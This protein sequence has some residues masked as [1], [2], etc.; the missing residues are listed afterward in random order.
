MRTATALL[1]AALL[2]AA[3]LA[4]PAWAQAPLANPGFEEGAP[5]LTGWRF[6]Q[7][8]RYAAALD[9]VGAREGRWAAH[10]TGQPGGGA[11][12]FGNL[13]QRVDAVPFRGQRLRFRAWVRTD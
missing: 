8:P 5:A 4:R 3:S 12:D 6:A 2:P 1:L 10:V 13:V 9:S 11:N 7:S